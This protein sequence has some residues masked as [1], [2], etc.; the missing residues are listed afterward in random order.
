MGPTWGVWP[1]RLTTESTLCILLVDRGGR[2]LILDLE[3]GDMDWTAVMA[4]VG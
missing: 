2:R 4:M 3:T 1:G